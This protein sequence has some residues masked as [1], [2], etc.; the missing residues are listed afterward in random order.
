MNDERHR[1]QRLGEIRGALGAHRKGWITYDSNQLRAL[2]REYDELARVLDQ[3]AY[4]RRRF[5]ADGFD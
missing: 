2:K 1:E 3:K 5:Y 4:A